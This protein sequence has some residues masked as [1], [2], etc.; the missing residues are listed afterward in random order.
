[1][2]HNQRDSIM[3]IEPTAQAE[4]ESKFPWDGRWFSLDQMVQQAVIGSLLLLVRSAMQIVKLYI[5][6]K[7]SRINPLMKLRVLLQ[8]GSFSQNRRSNSMSRRSSL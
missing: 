5:L 4:T 1:M 7:Q 8:A 6:L 3:Q 2:K